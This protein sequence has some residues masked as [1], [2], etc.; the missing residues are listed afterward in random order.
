MSRKFFAILVLAL[1]G[2]SVLGAP[3]LAENLGHLVLY[4]HEAHDPEAGASHQPTN[5]EHG[6]TGTLHLC[7]CHT[8][9]SF[10]MSQSRAP[11]ATYAAVT[12]SLISRI[13]L[14]TGFPHK[15]YHPPRA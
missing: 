10:V 6:C 7:G 2:S 3:E 8:S 4:G 11:A 9:M 12:L 1:L 13:D 15:P 5:P 14:R